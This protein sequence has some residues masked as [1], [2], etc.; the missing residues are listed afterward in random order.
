MVQNILGHLAGLSALISIVSISSGVHAQIFVS[1]FQ[2][3]CVPGV[4]K[5]LGHLAGLSALGSTKCQFHRD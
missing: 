2:N 5:I 3:R 1:G 4:Q